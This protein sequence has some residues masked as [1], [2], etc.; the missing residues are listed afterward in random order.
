MTGRRVPRPIKK[1]FFR[2]TERER[3]GGEIREGG[4]RRDCAAPTASIDI[5]SPMAL[6]FTGGG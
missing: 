6:N 4:E 5:K 3:E 2:G 1:Q